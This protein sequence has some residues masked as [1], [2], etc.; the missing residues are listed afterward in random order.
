MSTLCGF[1]ALSHAVFP[2]HSC[3]ASILQELEHRKRARFSILIWSAIYLIGT[4]YRFIFYHLKCFPC[5]QLSQVLVVLESSTSQRG[6]RC[7]QWPSGW[8][9]LGTDPSP[10]LWQKRRLKQKQIRP[11]PCHAEG[12]SPGGAH[13]VKLMNFSVLCKKGGGA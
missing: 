7:S 11:N 10:R 8:G 2:F 4:F 6:G 12:K 1:Q 13:P 5:S 3:S 9:T